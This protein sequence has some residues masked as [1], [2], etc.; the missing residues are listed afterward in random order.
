MNSDW[1][2]ITE[3]ERNF[4][5]GNVL[6]DAWKIYLKTLGIGAIAV[7]LYGVVSIVITQILSEITG[8]NYAQKQLSQNLE[9]VGDFNV[10]SQELQFYYVENLYPIISTALLSSLIMLLAFPLAGGFMLVCRE[11][12][13]KGVMNIGTLFEGFKPQYWG[14]L[15]VLAILY[16]VISKIAAMLFVIPAIYFWVAAV[17]GCPLIMFKNMSGVEALKT[18]INLVNKNFMNVAIVLVV[19]SLFGLAGYFMCG[20]GRILTYP[21]VLV[22]VYTLYKYLVED[23]LDEVSKI[24]EN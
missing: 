21:F 6:N 20:V 8:L 15:M 13:T 1:N 12:E 5:A 2:P 22:T 17:L 9:G 14:R 4:R 18:S 16:F 23:D 19:A 7:T 24:G 11:W 10:L 3:N